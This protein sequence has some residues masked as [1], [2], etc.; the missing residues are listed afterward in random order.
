MDLPEVT[1]G[2]AK[3]TAGL[4]VIELLQIAGFTTSNGE[5]RRLI[6]GGGARL[7]D[8][9]ISD[10]TQTVSRVDIDENLGGMKV[11]SGKKKHVLI[12]VDA[13]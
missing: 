12:K 3:L 5:S 10:E 4:S 2:Q 9:A 8:L 1:I 7:N 13:L 6:K 11:S